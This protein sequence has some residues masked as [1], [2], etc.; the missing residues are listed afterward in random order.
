METLAT[1]RGSKP[2]ARTGGS[3]SSYSSD[4]QPDGPTMM[5]GGIGAG[6]GPS[7]WFISCDE[8]GP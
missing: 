3:S 2:D 6:R 4:I 1:F 5:G 7:G 8:E